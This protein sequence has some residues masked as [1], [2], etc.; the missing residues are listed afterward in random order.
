MREGLHITEAFTQ[1]E[2][3]ISILGINFMNIDLLFLVKHS[4]VL[5]NQIVQMKNSH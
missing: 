4:F 5:I 2:M 1:L 3:Y